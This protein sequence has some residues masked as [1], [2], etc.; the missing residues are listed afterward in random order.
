M[1]DKM[2]KIHSLFKTRE[3]HPNVLCYSA[4]SPLRIDFEKNKD[5]KVLAL[6]QY[7]CFNLHEKLNWLPS[8]L[9]PV[10]KKWLVF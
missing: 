9:S 10:E 7:V 8:L 1:Q 5:P 4:E 3:R 2:H 6:R